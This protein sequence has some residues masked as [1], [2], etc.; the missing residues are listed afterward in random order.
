MDALAE[1]IRDHQASAAQLDLCDAD[2][3]EAWMR[4]AAMLLAEMPDPFLR[5]EQAMNFSIVLSVRCG[6]CSGETL[7]KIRGD[8]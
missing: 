3:R 1:L 8:A 5:I 6:T 4:T 2:A 7:R